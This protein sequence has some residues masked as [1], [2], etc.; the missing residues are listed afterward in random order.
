MTTKFKFGIEIEFHVKVSDFGQDEIAAANKISEI[1]NNNG[2]V[3]NDYRYTH[4]VSQNWKIM[5]DGSLDDINLRYLGLEVVS[6]ILYGLEGIEEVKKC[7]HILDHVVKAIVK[8]D[9]GIHVHFDAEDMTVPQIWNIY[10]AY[11]LNEDVFDLIMPHSR[12]ANHNTYCLPLNEQVHDIE[13]V[14]APTTL[15]RLRRLVGFNRY[16]KVNLQSLFR[17]NTIE[18]RQHSGSLNREKVSNWIKLLYSFI[19]NF[20]DGGTVEGNKWER[21]H[22]ILSGDINI[23]ETTVE[24]ANSSIPSKMADLKQAIKLY[25]DNEDLKQMAANLGIDT[26][27]RKKATWQAL[28]AHLYQQTQIQSQTAYTEFANN[29]VPFYTARAYALNA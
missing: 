28:Y 12:K 29:L 5:Q 4:Q 26:D 27:L 3:C 25:Y 7:L 19:Q 9:C 10:K 13:N 2:V 21:L 20:K 6:P 16:H 17:Q 8:K 23:P 18:F 11:A 14:L 22:K 15:S 1:L 24:N